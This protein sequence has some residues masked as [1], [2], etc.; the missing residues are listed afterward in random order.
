MN[1]LE[2]EFTPFIVPECTVLVRRLSTTGILILTKEQAQ[3][4]YHERDERIW[5]IALQ[6]LTLHHAKDK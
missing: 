3:Y 5:T 1:G 6:V 2:A 4:A